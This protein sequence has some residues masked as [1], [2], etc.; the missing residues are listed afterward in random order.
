MRRPNARNR[1][2]AE[3]PGNGAIQPC[4][5]VPL[6]RIPASALREVVS[7]SIVLIRLT[8]RQIGLPPVRNNTLLA[9]GLCYRGSNAKFLPAVVGGLR[10]VCVKTY[11]EDASLFGGAGVACG[12]PANEVNPTW[13]LNLDVH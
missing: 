8:V 7:G 1:C 12:Q 4:L 10:R 2:D 11:P 3:G 9:V 5:S 13:V 6:V